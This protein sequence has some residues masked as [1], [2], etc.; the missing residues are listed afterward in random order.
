[1]LS[2]IMGVLCAPFIFIIGMFIF[3]KT[4]ASLYHKFKGDY[5]DWKNC[6]GQYSWYG[7]RNNE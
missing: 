6:E 5:K 3:E 1:M 4:I 7:R 2:F